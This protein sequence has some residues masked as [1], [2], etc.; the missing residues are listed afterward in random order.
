MATTPLEATDKTLFRSF[1]VAASNTIARGMPVKFSGTKIV[2][3]ETT[4][5][6]PIGI[7]MEA[8]DGD[9]AKIRNIRVA[10]LGSPGIVPLLC[11]GV[12]NPG[13]YATPGTN[14]AASITPGG[15]STLKGCLGQM[16]EAGAAGELSGCNIGLGGPVYTA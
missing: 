11:S 16:M 3:S 9:N 7:A 5:D 4:T 12:I 6:Q 14:G 15:G 1:E 13:A 2:K 10:M 8:G